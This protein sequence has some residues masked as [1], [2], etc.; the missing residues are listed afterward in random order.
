MSYKVDE[1]NIGAPKKRMELCPLSN[2]AIAIAFKSDKDK[3]LERAMTQLKIGRAINKLE[4]IQFCYHNFRKIFWYR[5]KNYFSYYTERKV[6]KTLI[7]EK[8]L[9]VKIIKKWKS[10]KYTDSIQWN[11]HIFRK[12]FKFDRTPKIFSPTFHRFHWKPVYLTNWSNIF[13]IELQEFI[14]LY[15][16]RM[17]KNK[18]QIR[19]F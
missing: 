1:N 5:T 3:Q 2:I 9:R 14:Q 19:T 16:Y 17:S 10:L 18:Y 13:V 8:S 12:N 11:Y 15:L 6:A 7:F 4:A